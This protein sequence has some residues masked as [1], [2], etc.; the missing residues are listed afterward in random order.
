MMNMRG[1]MGVEVRRGMIGE[2]NG[3]PIMREGE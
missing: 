2:G 1:R 3:R